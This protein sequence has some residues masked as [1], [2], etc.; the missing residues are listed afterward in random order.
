MVT[1]DNISAWCDVMYQFQAQYQNLLG[2]G[3]ATHWITNSQGQRS[4]ANNKSQSHNVWQASSWYPPVSKGNTMAG[5]WTESITG[6]PAHP[7][8]MGWK[9]AKN[10]WRWLTKL[11][12]KL[13]TPTYYQFVLCPLATGA[14]G[15]D[16][17]RTMKR[18]QVHLSKRKGLKSLSPWLCRGELSQF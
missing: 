1:S 17:E 3:W 10:F 4:L 13:L 9:N 12:T 15:M 16:A 5:H 7:W 14:L 2:T 8:R 18:D 6:A 11:V